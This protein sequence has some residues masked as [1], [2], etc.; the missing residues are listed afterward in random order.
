[1]ILLQTD[2]NA[3]VSVQWIRPQYSYQSAVSYRYI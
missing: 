1:M 3:K 2:M